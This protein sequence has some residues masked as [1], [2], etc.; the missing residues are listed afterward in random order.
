MRVC[1]CVC[2]CVKFSLTPSSLPFPTRV[3]FRAVPFSLVFCTLRFAFLSLPPLPLSLSSLASFWWHCVLVGFN[4]MRGNYII[5]WGRSSVFFPHF[6]VI[7]YLCLALL[8]PFPL[9]RSS[10]LASLF[11]RLFCLFCLLSPF[12]CLCVSLST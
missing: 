2:V 12:L 10:A 8:L 5:P 11:Y 6:P 4:F 9:L 1:V 7:Y 3:S